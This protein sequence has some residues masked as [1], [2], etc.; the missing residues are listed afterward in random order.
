MDKS[1][2]KSH[3]SFTYINNGNTSILHTE[4]VSSVLLAE[5]VGT[6]LY[7]YSYSMLAERYKTL[8]RILPNAL[9]C[10]SVKA[11][12]N[13]SIIHSLAQLGAGADVVSGG[14]L[15]R[16]I[17]AGVPTNKIVFAGVGKTEDEMASALNAGIL[18]IN[19]ESEPELEQ[20]NSVA[21]KLGKIAPVAVR[22]NPDVDAKTHDKIA[23]GRR[24]DKFGVPY[25]MAQHLYKRISELPAVEAVGLATHIG[26]Q[27]MS[28]QPFEK[29]FTRLGELAHTLKTDGHNIKNLDFGGGL[30]V[31]YSNQNEPSIDQYASI[32]LKTANAVGCHITIEPGRF[33][34]APAG[35]LLT[36]VIYVKRTQS[37]TFVIVDSAMNDFIRPALYDASHKVEPIIKPEKS[38]ALETVDIVGPICESGDFLAKNK[39]LPS[40]NPGDLLA[41]RDTGA[42]GATMSSHYN[43]RIPAGEVL[44]NG[45]MWS[46]I[47]KQETIEDVIANEPLAHWLT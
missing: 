1:F 41:I 2:S 44:V 43:S 15:I 42:Y 20:L 14:E 34:A 33:I 13:I 39:K 46:V 9:I 36:R 24:D 29:A 10:F 30:G 22:I 17:K 28:L 40:L 3:N 38:D 37:R 27:L 23:T 26:S 21:L 32:L 35:I 25:E 47:K 12:A 11:N 18:Q 5:T 45:K 4:E 8:A 7:V 16:A 31:N 19:I 6:P